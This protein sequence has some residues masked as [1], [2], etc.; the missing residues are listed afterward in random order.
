VYNSTGAAP[1]YGNSAGKT[2]LAG[3]IVG[4]R[5]LWSGDTVKAAVVILAAG[6]GSRAGGDGQALPKQYRALG[7]IPVVNRTLTAFAE[8]DRIGEIVVVVHADEQDMFAR[9]AAP[10]ADRLRAP[11]IGGATRQESALAGLETLAPLAPQNVLIHDA[12]RP[13]VSP[14]LIDRV[15]DELGENDAVVPALPVS[16]TLKK[17]RGGYVVETL[18]RSSLR[19][20]QTPQ[21][22]R[23]GAILDAHKAAAKTAENGFTDDASI[24]EWQGARVALVEGDKG[25]VKLTTAED[26]AMAEKQIAAGESRVGQGFDV[27]AFGDGGPL[28]LCGVTIPHPRGLTGHSDADVGLHALTDALLGAIG[29]GDIG[30]HFPPGDPTWAGAASDRFLSDAA[31]RIRTRGGTIINVDVTI[32]CEE[33]KIG[34]HRQAMI[35]AIATILEIEPGRV[36]VKATTTERLGFTGRNE[37]IAASATATVRMS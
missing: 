24:A 34:P 3:V 21:G 18:E 26:F 6:K 7:G 16:D 31:A 8:H 1:Y 37:G 27:H 17:E 30:T 22:F 9:T 12:A 36:S 33:P 10:F 19:T 14:G 5:W 28:I 4:L 15:I 11:V 25:N 35:E 23:F 32:I 2:A 29:D 13:F 20:A